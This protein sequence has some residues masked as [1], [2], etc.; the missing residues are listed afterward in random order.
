M[1]VAASPT[2]TVTSAKKHA[3]LEFSVLESCK[4]ASVLFI[5]FLSLSSLGMC[6][7]GG[8]GCGKV[9]EEWGGGEGGVR[10]QLSSHN[11]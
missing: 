5:R 11:C 7:G 2:M 10:A 9:V 4:H 8:R 6:G 1:P 3:R